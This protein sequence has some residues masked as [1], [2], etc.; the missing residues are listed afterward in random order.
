V[1]NFTEISGFYAL[2]VK[3]AN[4]LKLAIC[5]FEVVFFTADAKIFIRH[6]QQSFTLNFYTGT[7]TI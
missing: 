3:T 4:C 5:G 1:R 6:N 2:F 7:S